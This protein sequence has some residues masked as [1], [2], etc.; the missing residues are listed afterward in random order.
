M[1]P[2]ICSPAWNS[3]RIACPDNLWDRAASLIHCS[4][5]CVRHNLMQRNI[6]HQLHYCNDR[7]AKMSPSVRR[8][9]PTCQHILVLLG[10]TLTLC[11]SNWLLAFESLLSI[12]NRALKLNPLTAKLRIVPTGEG[13]V[14]LP[15]CWP[16]KI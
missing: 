13:S 1:M 14:C 6:F 3:T 11:I 9:C 2:S 15:L 10:H 7:L 5:F 12:C 4:F 8:E 16:G